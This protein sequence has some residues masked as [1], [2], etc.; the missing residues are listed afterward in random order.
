MIRA[1]ILTTLLLFGVPPVRLSRVRPFQ[2]ESG[3]ISTC[4][5]IGCHGRRSECAMYTTR[6]GDATFTSHFCYED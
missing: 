6:N 3:W 4:D 2:K 1:L 5:G